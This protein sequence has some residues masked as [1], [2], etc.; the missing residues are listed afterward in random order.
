MRRESGAKAFKSIDL[1]ALSRLGLRRRR[2]DVDQ[3]V[4]VD[5]MTPLAQAQATEGVQVHRPERS[6]AGF[7]THEWFSPL[8]LMANLPLLSPCLG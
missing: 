3:H 1:N 5:I 6:G 4:L 2:H 7:A 8:P